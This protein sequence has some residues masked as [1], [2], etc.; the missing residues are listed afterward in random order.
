VPTLRALALAVRARVLLEQGRATEALGAAR[1]G[2]ALVAAVGGTEE[3]DAQLR[4]VYAEALRALGHYEAA[5]EAITL[6]M[7]RL[8]ARAQRIQEPG[9]RAGFCQSVPEN[10]KTF[11]LAA[12]WGQEMDVTVG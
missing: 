3:G 9:R 11:A 5:R 12:M 8:L 10:A 7:Q 1:E 2:L 6:A 4:L